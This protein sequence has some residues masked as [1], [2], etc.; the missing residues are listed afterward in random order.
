MDNPLGY[1]AAVWRMFRD[2]PRAGRLPAGPAAE[3]GTPA[4]P[5]RLR[6]QVRTEGQRI[7]DTAFQAHGCPYT[8]ATGAWL[9]QWLIGRPAAE[10]ARPPIAELRAELEI[11]QDRA[12][13]WLMAQDGRGELHRLLESS[14][15]R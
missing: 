10:C 15:P 3:V 13:C 4:A 8:V 9:A 5:F 7:V 1:P 6:L 12:H 11:P 14:D 2:T